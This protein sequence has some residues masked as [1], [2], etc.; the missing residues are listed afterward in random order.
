MNEESPPAAL[1]ASSTGCVRSSE[2]H[3][4]TTVAPCSASFSAVTRPIPVLAPVMTA[5]LPA[6]SLAVLMGVVFISR[7][8][9]LPPARARRQLDQQARP[10]SWSGAVATVDQHAAAYFVDVVVRNG[11]APRHAASS[12]LTASFSVVGEVVVERE[13]ARVIGQR[14]P[15]GP[16]RR[17]RDDDGRVDALRVMPPSAGSALQGV[18]AQPPIAQHVERTSLEPVPVEVRRSSL[19]GLSVAVAGS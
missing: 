9:Q 18:D 6:S 12:R 2:R 7:S 19:R 16:P 14:S 15:F 3:A 1:M 5:V 17:Q 13:R 11:S 10:P 4:N 8:R